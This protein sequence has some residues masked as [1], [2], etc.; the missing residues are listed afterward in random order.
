MLVVSIYFDFAVKLQYTLCIKIFKTL[1][2]KN[3]KP[4]TCIHNSLS[5]FIHIYS[6]IKLAYKNVLIIQVYH[7]KPYK[8]PFII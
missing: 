3:L 4:F 2:K 5:Y 6:Y 7:Y 8:P 1:I